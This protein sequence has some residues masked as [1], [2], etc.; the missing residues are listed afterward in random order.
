MNAAAEP[1][2]L[3]LNWRPR[4]IEFRRPL[5]M[6]PEATNASKLMS[7]TSK[8]LHAATDSHLV[9]T[10]E[11]FP[12]KLVYSLAD[13]SNAAGEKEGFLLVSKAARVVDVIP[14]VRKAVAPEK[15][16]SC[17]RIWSKMDSLRPGGKGATAKGDGYELV[18]LDRLDGKLAPL[19]DDEGEPS[20]MT[21]EDWVSRH[22]SNADKIE[23]L[24]ILV[25]T[26][27]SP[28]AKWAREELELENRLQVDF[29]REFPNVFERSQSLIVRFFVVVF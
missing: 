15:S 29:F 26:R 25:E 7:P 27:A 24:D 28:S 23:S 10:V 6:V 18:H 4:A 16:S 14:A 8:L 12:I 21:M 3:D 17:V 2:S 5:L 20:K 22:L 19:D 1:D 9:P 13:D 11:A